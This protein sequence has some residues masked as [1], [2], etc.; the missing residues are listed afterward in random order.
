MP[1]LEVRSESACLCQDSRPI[2]LC[3][4]RCEKCPGSTHLCGYTP[5]CNLFF[6][7]VMLHP[8]TK[9]HGVIPLTDRQSNKPTTMKTLSQGP[10][11]PSS[12]HPL[13]RECFLDSTELGD[14]RLPVPHLICHHVI[15]PMTYSLY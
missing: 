9:F 2:F 13:D 6:P 5:K 7:W 8:S 1:K 12:N 15:I 4:R 10:T 11:V 3:L 14:T